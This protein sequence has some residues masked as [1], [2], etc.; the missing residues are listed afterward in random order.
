MCFARHK[1]FFVILNK[2]IL[3]LRADSLIHKD[4]VLV[5]LWSAKTQSFIE[6]WWQSN[7]SIKYK[8]DES[9]PLIK[10]STILDTICPNSQAPFENL[11][12]IT[13]PF[14]IMIWN[15]DF[16]ICLR[17]FLKFFFCHQ[18]CLPGSIPDHKSSFLHTL[19]IALEITAN[20]ITNCNEREVL[21]VKLVSMSG[22]KLDQTLS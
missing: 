9:C 18:S 10:C 2:L 17:A 7:N 14:H 11:L 12:V 3:L 8:C 6:N 13:L 4:R 20:T 5:S 16:A 15:V 1:Y 19:N 22:S 21:R